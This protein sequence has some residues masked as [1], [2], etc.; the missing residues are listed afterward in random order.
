MGRRFGYR[1]RDLPITEELSGCLLR[2]PFYYDLT[3][4]EQLRVV[5]YATEFIEHPSTKAC[6]IK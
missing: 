6:Y 5:K 4:E 3:E 2:L 1:A